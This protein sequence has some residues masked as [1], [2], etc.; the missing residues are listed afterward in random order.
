MIWFGPNSPWRFLLLLLPLCVCRKF[1]RGTSKVYGCT[2]AQNTHMMFLP[3]SIPTARLCP[4]TCSDGTEVWIGVPGK[5]NGVS[6]PK[7]GSFFFFSPSLMAQGWMRRCCGSGQCREEKSVVAIS[8]HSALTR[9]YNFFS[10]QDPY[11]LQH[12]SVSWFHLYFDL[13]ASTCIYLK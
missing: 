6:H 10:K 5:Q 9:C 11:W 8:P 7:S 12:W 3:W 2:I 13:K 4:Q 1:S